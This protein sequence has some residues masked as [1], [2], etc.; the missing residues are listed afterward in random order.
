MSANP[1][2]IYGPGVNDTSKR[3]YIGPNFYGVN[4]IVTWDLDGTV[5]AGTMCPRIQT[6]PI[7][8][9]NLTYISPGVYEIIFYI[10]DENTTV[11]KDLPD[12]TIY[13]YLN[14]K[15]ETEI[16]VHNGI[17]LLKL[18]TNDYLSNQT[19]EIWISAGSLFDEERTFRV[20]FYYNITN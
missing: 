9:N 17:G 6:T 5:G 13:G 18:D 7:H 11:A 16:N 4:T 12:F 19:N 20:I 8:F 10:D 1:N 2:G 14:G 15:N 3:L